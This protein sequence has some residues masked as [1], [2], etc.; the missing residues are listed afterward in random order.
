MDF[1]II[2]LKRETKSQIEHDLVAFNCKTSFYL[3][4]C[5][6]TW[7]RKAQWSE[8]KRRG[9]QIHFE[10]LVDNKSGFLSWQNNFIGTFIQMIRGTWDPLMLPIFWGF[11]FT[12]YYLYCYMASLYYTCDYANC[13]NLEQFIAVDSSSNHLH[14]M[15]TGH[16]AMS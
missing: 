5:S 7:T 8:T 2:L 13:L 1:F 15:K 9:N 6:L 4:I 11:I 3:S 14:H 10:T 16:L 12:I